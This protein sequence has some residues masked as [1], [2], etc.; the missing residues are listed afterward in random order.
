MKKTE[1][2]EGGIQKIDG[3]MVSKNAPSWGKFRFVS[4]A[5]SKDQTRFTMTGIHIERVKDKTLIISTDGKRLHIASID[6][7]NI[8]PGDYEVKEN[9]RDFMVLYPTADEIS[10]PNWRQIIRGLETQKHLEINLTNKDKSDFSQNLYSLFKATE[11]PINFEFLEPLANFSSTWDVYFNGSF[12][13]HTFVN[14]D[15]MAIIMPMA[16]RESLKVEETVNGPDF[17]DI[18][19][20]INILEFKPVKKQ[21]KTA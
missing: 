21:R 16:E 20:E 5:K 2:I 14:G 18:T 13:A 17:R 19:P 9:T 3:I 10:Y 6:T 1:F 4:G 7:L 11:A 8:E 15:L 12:K